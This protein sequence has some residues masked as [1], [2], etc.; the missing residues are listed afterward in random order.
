M[1][2]IRNIISELGWRDGV[3]YVLD[4]GFSSYAP[5][6]ALITYRFYAQPVVPTP[7]A[8]RARKSKTTY[9]LVDRGDPMIASLGLSEA[10]LRHRFDQGAICIGAEKDG[11][12]IGT[13][14]LVVGPFE[15]DEVRCRY[16]PAPEGQACW[17]LG[18]FVRP[19]HRLGLAFARLWETANAHLAERGVRYS[20]SRISA[21]NKIS[22]TAHERLGARRIGQARFLR[23]GRLQI[24]WANVAPFFGISLS[25]ARQPCF[26]LRAPGV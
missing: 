22:C 1:D 21:Y 4:R 10:V 13:I 2:R 25:R 15:E 18:V 17:D 8:G 5:A 3:A 26:H 9:R 7:G 12:L 23:L 19:D 16:V 20:L 11:A 6:C 14:W 24:M